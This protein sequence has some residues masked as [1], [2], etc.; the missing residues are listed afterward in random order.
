MYH[1]NIATL[2]STAHGVPVFDSLDF[3]TPWAG[4]DCIHLPRDASV[5]SDDGYQHG[6]ILLDGDIEF[7]TDGSEGTVRARMRQ[8]P[9]WLVAAPDIRHTIDS[10]GSTPAILVR[11]RVLASPQNCT[12]VLMGRFDPQLLAWRDSIHGGRG[13]LATRHVLR[14]A[15][16]ASSWTY[17]DHAVLGPGSSLGYH[18]HEGLEE[19]FVVLAGQGDMTVDDQTFQVTPGSVTFQAI[20]TAHGL[21]NPGPDALNFV[22]LAVAMP[23]QEPTTVDLNHDLQHRRAGPGG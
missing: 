11:V 7:Q 15:Q 8:P 10:R 4:L 20:G 5:E 9:G 23:D 14:P 21:H 18:C 16:L 3:T 6:Y 19:A 22:R 17:L 13:Q 1:V 12:G 2:D